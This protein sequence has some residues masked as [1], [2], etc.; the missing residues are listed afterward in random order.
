MITLLVC[1]DDVEER[2][3]ETDDE[4]IERDSGDNDVED[5][6]MPKTTESYTDNATCTLKTIL[7]VSLYLYYTLIFNRCVMIYFDKAI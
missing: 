1:E 4:G 7:Q 5:Y 2:L 6:M 3:Q